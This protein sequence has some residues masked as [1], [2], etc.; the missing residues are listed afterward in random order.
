MTRSRQLILI[1]LRNENIILQLSTDYNRTNGTFFVYDPMTNRCCRKYAIWV[2]PLLFH[3][4]HAP[5]AS[6]SGPAPKYLNLG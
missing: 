6:V 3:P 2:F 5:V 4:G 1:E